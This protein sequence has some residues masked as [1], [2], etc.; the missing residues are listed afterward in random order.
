[1]SKKFPTDEFDFLEPHGGRHRARRT[2]RDRARE[3]TRILVVAAVAGII[4]L[5]GLRIIDSGVQFDGSALPTASAAA[6]VISVG[7]TVLDSTDTDGLASSTAQK[8]V[9]AGWNVL[10]ADNLNDGLTRETTIVYIA[11]EDNRSDAKKVLK[12]LGKYSIEV[13]SSYTDPITVVLASDFK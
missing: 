11:S 13:S 3:F 5:G 2:K 7:V 12:T 9:D 8:L 1:M 4:G 6:E 10:T